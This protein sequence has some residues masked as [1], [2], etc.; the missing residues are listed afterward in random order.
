LILAK[1]VKIQEAGVNDWLFSKKKF[2]LLGQALAL[3]VVGYFLLAQ[4]PVDSFLSKSVAPVI[5][6]VVYCVLIPYLLISDYGR[7]GK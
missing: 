7:G 6:V 1:R 5:L 2:Y 3:L 4:G